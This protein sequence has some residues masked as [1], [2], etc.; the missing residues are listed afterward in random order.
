MHRPVI[1]FLPAVLER[2]LAAY[3]LLL[4]PI[5]DA[6]PDEVFG[7]AL[8]SK[9]TFRYM[10]FPFM[11]E[12]E[13]V[14]RA[15][16][17]AWAQ[18]RVP[19][20]VPA[21][22]S[23]V[24][25]II[26]AFAEAYVGGLSADCSPG[27]TAGSA[28]INSQFNHSP[29]VGHDN[30]ATSQH[31]IPGVTAQ[32]LAGAAVLSWG[33]AWLLLGAASGEVPRQPEVGAP[34]PRVS[35]AV[36]VEPGEAVPEDG[37]AAA[38]TP[39]I[40]VVPV[41]PASS[42]TSAF[43]SPP[44]SVLKVISA[45]TTLL[46]HRLSGAQHTQ[47]TASTTSCFRSPAQA[48]AMAAVF[49]RKRDVFA[50]FPTGGGKSLLF[51]VP[52][53]VEVTAGL[54]TVVV[55]PLIAL[56]VDMMRRCKES[57]IP[58]VCWTPGWAREHPDVLP[59]GI[60]LVDVTRARLPGFL[61]ALRKAMTNNRLARVVFDECHLQS[62]WFGFRPRDMAVA[63]VIAAQQP[64]GSTPVPFLMLSATVPPGVELDWAKHYFGS[65]APIIVR[66]GTDRANLRYGVSAVVEGGSTAHV[67]SAVVECITK[68]APDIQSMP[69][70][71]SRVL[72]Y[73]RSKDS[74]E[75]L[76]AA[77]TACG[78][79]SSFYHAGMEGEG[80]S[81]AAAVTA[82]RGGVTPVMCCTT[83]FSIGV[84]YSSVRLVVHAGLPYSLSQ[85]AQEAGRAGR[86][87]LPAACQ[88]LILPTS[89]PAI[90]ES[91]VP[92]GMKQQ[93][94]DAR[95]VADWAWDDQSCRR[96]RLQSLFDGPSYATSMGPCALQLETVGV[97][98]E[99]CDV[100]ASPS[101]HE[102]GDG[103][104]GFVGLR[105]LPGR[106]EVQESFAAA[107]DLAAKVSVILSTVGAAHCSL[108]H[109]LGV[110]TQCGGNGRAGS[111][112]GKMCAV[113]GKSMCYECGAKASCRSSACG[114]KSHIARRR[115]ANHLCSQCF[116]PAKVGGIAF[117]RAAAADPFSGEVGRANMH[118][119]CNSG[120]RSFL[121][122]LAMHV[123][124]DPQLRQGLL[125]P[126][127]LERKLNMFAVQ[128][129]Y[130][131]WLVTCVPKNDGLPGIAEVLL[132][133]SIW[134]SRVRSQK[135]A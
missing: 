119:D 15:L 125:R 92:S 116:L 55:V 51:M 110:E 126:F 86:D 72:V 33:W 89:K 19:G 117:H 63:L 85:Y 64:L 114:I 62:E 65:S 61:A 101:T 78:L 22:L 41:R 90:L 16:R 81:R 134:G 54:V 14:S 132:E 107:H 34:A 37:Q 84:D 45:H 68:L 108:C 80:R 2:I 23:T 127:L 49:E 106:R 43:Y 76:A 42:T 4:R 40:L 44:S 1:R 57:R 5:L 38:A 66:T 59:A 77:L 71:A 111:G 24:R 95:A 118:T 7:V 113:R 97:R 115:D 17:L 58:C 3:I 52:A 56:L 8:P 26:Q 10:I 32:T 39:P 11:T 13:D 29:N 135:K 31:Q 120:G 87:G 21:N 130:A 105:S 75:V 50:I 112:A 124:V 131:L 30:Y 83:A 46:V 67:A 103:G 123:F 109:V 25:H 122:E 129:E 99:L 28:L 93:L 96:L 133:C 36:P 48:V 102:G 82:W 35:P 104:G 73:V 9:A 128:K 12:S 47:P 100:C 6:L 53:D 91:L 69:R 18:S 98:R 20:L 94:A 79:P 88:L 121:W 70:S 74:A 60:V 27:R